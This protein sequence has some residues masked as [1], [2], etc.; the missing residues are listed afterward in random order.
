MDLRD[1]AFPV[2]ERKVAVHDGENSLIDL[3]RHDTFLPNEYKAIVRED[4]N[5]LISI[6]RESYQIVPNE[7][8]ISRLMEELDKTNTPFEIEPSHSFVEN[9][10]MRLQVKFPEILINDGRSDIALS[11]YLHNSYDMSEGIRMFWG[12][13]RGICTNGMVFGKILGTIYKRHT[14]GFELENIETELSRM[15]DLMPRI[16]NRIA[17]LDSRPIT[18]DIREEVEKDLGKKVA[19][20]I[21]QSEYESQWKLYNAITYLVSHVIQQ[22]YR[23]RYQ[24]TTSRIFGL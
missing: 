9:N 22:K 15:S 8:I 17:D 5:E 23:A 3:E 2:I 7:R 14:S 24:M 10:R 21:F 16:Q 6:V 1:F 12:A 20:Q 4:T 18:S 19:A 11:L 13:I